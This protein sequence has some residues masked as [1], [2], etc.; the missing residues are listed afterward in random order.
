MYSG[1]TIIANLILWNVTYTKSKSSAASAE[2]RNI[3]YSYI[4]VLP[5]LCIY[6]QKRGFTIIQAPDKIVKRNKGNFFAFIVRQ[7]QITAG[8]LRRVYAILSALV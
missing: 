6:F 5:N 3:G 4:A 7:Y 1:L 8:R 2:S